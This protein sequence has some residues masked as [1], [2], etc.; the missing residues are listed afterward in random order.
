MAVQFGVVT[1]PG[2]FGFIQNFSRTETSDLGEARDENGD[3]ATFNVYN[4]R[5]ECSFEYIFEGTAPVVGDALTADGTNS[6]LITGVTETEDNQDFK[7]LSCT[8][9]HWQTNS[10]P[11]NPA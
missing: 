4:E 3:V 6:F 10:I 11:P 2:S 8:G 5:F 7:K 1:A 9:T